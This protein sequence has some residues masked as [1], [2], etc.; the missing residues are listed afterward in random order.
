MP[1]ALGE[2]GAGTKRE[3]ASV[4]AAKLGIN[5]SV[6]GEL[7]DIRE[8]KS[9]RKASNANEVFARYLKLVEQVTAAI[10]KMLDPA[11]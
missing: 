4:L 5:A 10:D 11:A 8:H 6:F 1:M 2:A 9:Q 3:A 7:L